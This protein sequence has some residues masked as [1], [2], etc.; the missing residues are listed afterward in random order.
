MSPIRLG[1]LLALASSALFPASTRLDFTRITWPQGPCDPPKLRYLA[2]PPR[3]LDR[4]YSIDY[5][6][7][8][9]SSDY[10][11]GEG[12]AVEGSHPRIS[13]AIVQTRGLEGIVN[14]VYTDTYNAIAGSV[15][16]RSVFN[17]ARCNGQPISVTAVL[18]F[19]FDLSGNPSSDGSAVLD[20]PYSGTAPCT[21]PLV[22]YRPEILPNKGPPYHVR[23]SAIVGSDGHLSN[24]RIVPLAGA[25]IPT[26]WVG[27][28]NQQAMSA[29]PLWKVRPAFCGGNPISMTSYFDFLFNHHE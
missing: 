23:L 7:E 28:Y 14:A 20:H 2:P 11:A 16:Q 3:F 5:E 17:P 4:S 25:P 21:E 26:D 6:I 18:R 15:V 24:I 1:V 10:V 27:F 19:A 29:L 8:I 12:F 13:G 9:K 22:T